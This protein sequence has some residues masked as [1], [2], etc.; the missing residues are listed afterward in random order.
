MDDNTHISQT[1]GEVKG[2]D[3]HN[4]RAAGVIDENARIR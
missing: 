1:L 4:E 3:R 2:L